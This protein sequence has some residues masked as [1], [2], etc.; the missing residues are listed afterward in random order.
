[1]VE[2]KPVC[3]VDMDCTIA[4]LYP[5]LIRRCNKRFSLNLD[6]KNWRQ[7]FGDHE[8]KTPFLTR[9]MVDT[10]FSSGS[11][12]YDLKP[13]PGS[14]KALTKLSRHF[15]I[16][17]VTNPYLQA[18]RPF[19]DKYEWLQEYFS[20]F[21]NKMIATKHKYLIRGDILVDDHMPF[22]KKWKDNSFDFS[23]GNPFGQKY[24]ASLQYPWTDS[25]IVDIMD[26]TWTGLT[27]K[28]METFNV[29]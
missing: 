20:R 29:S 11:F 18:D 9:S 14:Q 28:I 16:Y 3:L 13:I 22:C 23:Q 27:R 7:Y 24:V 1:M 6:T 5:E 19:L 8:I 17:I 10:V 25:S 2:N 4:D 15:D 12:F 21:A 26:K